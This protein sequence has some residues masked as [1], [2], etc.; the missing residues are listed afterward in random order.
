MPERFHFARLSSRPFHRY[1]A[2]TLADGYGR[3]E[4]PLRDCD[5]DPGLPPGRPTLRIAKARLTIGVST[6]LFLSAERRTGQ[7]SSARRRRRFGR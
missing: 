4:A 3:F 7:Q 5:A 1:L 6:H 2:A